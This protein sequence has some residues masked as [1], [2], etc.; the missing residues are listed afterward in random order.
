MNIQ[1]PHLRSTSTRARYLARFLLNLMVYGRKWFEP[2]ASDHMAGAKR[3]HQSRLPAV[4]RSLRIE[5]I[6]PPSYFPSGPTTAC[7]SATQPA[8][9]CCHTVIIRTGALGSGW[10]LLVPLIVAV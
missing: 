3:K 1:A 5:R 4:R 8:F 9:C 7:A 2:I 10:P 6:P